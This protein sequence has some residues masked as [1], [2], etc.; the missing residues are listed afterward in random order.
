MREGFMT[1]NWTK[2]HFVFPGFWHKNLL[3]ILQ[4][5]SYC[6]NK[7]FY[8]CQALE[9]SADHKEV[10]MLLSCS[11]VIAVYWIPNGPDNFRKIRTLQGPKLKSE[12]WMVPLIIGRN[13]QIIFYKLILIWKPTFRWRHNLALLAV[14]RREGSSPTCFFIIYLQSPLKSIPI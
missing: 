2:L 10:P 1:Y 9:R 5:P 11:L 13:D 7:Y 12:K 4:I 3:K 14:P 8:I 6:Q